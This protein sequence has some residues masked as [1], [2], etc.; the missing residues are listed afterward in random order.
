MGWFWYHQGVIWHVQVGRTGRAGKVGRVT[1]LYWPESA[2]L[3]AAI[4]AAMDAGEPVERAFSR[5]RGF[6]KRV[7]RY[8]LDGVVPGGPA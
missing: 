7:R 2:T 1:S 4:R 3:V 6:R 8:G 5:K